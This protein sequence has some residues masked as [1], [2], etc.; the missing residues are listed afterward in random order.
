[1][2]TQ[3]PRILLI[4]DDAAVRDAVSA[5]LRGDLYDVRSEADGTAIDRVRE[6]WQPDMAILDVRLQQGP[7]GMALARRLRH[8]GDLPIMFLTAADELADR[9]A[10]FDVGADDYMTKPFSVAE[11]LARVRALLRRSNVLEQ[12]SWELDDLVVNEAS[13]QAWRGQR[14]L[15]LT[16]TEFDVL[17]AL[18]RRRGQA[19]SKDHLLMTVWQFDSYDHNLVEVHIS[20]LR[21]KLEEDGEPRLVHTIRGV[22][23]ILRQ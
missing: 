16:R 12:A 15:A 17:A 18:G 9:L 6:E 11:L 5:A 14:E 20:A 23:Y 4:E 22:G 7:D 3:Q 21:R 8:D 2:S 1:M 10:G 19:T 13:R